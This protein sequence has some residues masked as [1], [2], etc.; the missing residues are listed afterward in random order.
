MT[1]G[2][3]RPLAKPSVPP[4]MKAGGLHGQSDLYPRRSQEIL[5]GRIHTRKV[6]GW[7]RE[8]K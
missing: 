2:S 6:A 3:G 4:P 5:P 1:L 7:S 8:V